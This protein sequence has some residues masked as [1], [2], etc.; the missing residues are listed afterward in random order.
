MAGPESKIETV[1]TRYAQKCGFMVRK[2]MTPGHRNAPDRI[3]FIQGNPGKVF[4]I[5]FKAPG[6]TPRPG[7]LREFKK[8]R[9]F[10][11]E[12]HVVDNTEE[13]RAIIDSYT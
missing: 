13:G 5:E 12:V 7:Q 6:E 3:F 4:F 8:L 10:G 9:E 11:F 1:V 2:Y